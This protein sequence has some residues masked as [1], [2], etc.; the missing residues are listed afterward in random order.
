MD[1][2]ATP[3][4]IEPA[5]YDEAHAVAAKTAGF[6]NLQRI[7]LAFHGYHDIFGQFPAAVLYGPDGKT[8]HSWR[9]ELLPVL[10]HY[11]DG[12]DANKLRGKMSRAKYDEL[13]SGC[14]YDVSQPWDSQKNRSA[15]EAI[16]EV[17]R[18]PND[19]A[20]SITTAFYAVVGSGTAFDPNEIASFTDI[21]GW[22][23]ST[24]MVVESRSQEPWTKP[25][26]I[27]YSNSATVPRFGGFTKDGFM[28]LTC[29]GAP[30][31][32]SDAVSPESL[33][34]LISKET[35]D[36]FSIMGIPYRYE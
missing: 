29:D 13:I 10:K 24:L 19:K 28:A 11:V 25:I 1:E 31:Y 21:K 34:A 20:D 5:S 8:P 17:Y 4:A 15:L 12:V 2:P 3:V 23:A 18:H 35:T 26:D 9:V 16:P 33:R 14:G 32:I 30:H 22:P 27:A 6:K 7:G 36:N